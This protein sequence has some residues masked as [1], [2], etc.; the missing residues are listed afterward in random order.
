MIAHGH[1][2]MSLARCMGM[3]AHFATWPHGED[4]AKNE[5]KRKIG[6]VRKQ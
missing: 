1:A 3:L 5:S 6:S 4:V 2:H